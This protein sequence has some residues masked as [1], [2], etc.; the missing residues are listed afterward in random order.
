MQKFGAGRTM[1]L[2]IS[3]QATDENPAR[4][5]IVR[6]GLLNQESA[7][8]GAPWGVAYHRIHWNR[9]AVRNLM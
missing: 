7:L 1:T 3:K 6:T 5:G 9:P 4:A 2:A 8:W